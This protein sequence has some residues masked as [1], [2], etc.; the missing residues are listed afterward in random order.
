MVDTDALGIVEANT[1]KISAL[2]FPVLIYF[3]IG[4]IAQAAFVF[5]RLVESTFSRIVIKTEVAVIPKHLASL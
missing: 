5:L 3:V 4:T 2:T 1:W